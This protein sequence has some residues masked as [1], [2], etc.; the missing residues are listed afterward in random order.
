[1]RFFILYTSFFFF[2]FIEEKTIS[3][4]F[5]FSTNSCAFFVR[6]TSQNNSTFF[7]FFHTP[8]QSLIA[9]VSRVTIIYV[10]FSPRTRRST[11]LLITREHSGAFNLGNR[12]DPKAASYYIHN[13][14]F[15]SRGTTWDFFVALNHC[16]KW[17]RLLFSHVAPRHTRRTE[18]SDAS[19]T[20][21]YCS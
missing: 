4:L 2:L 6:F 19:Q 18:W 10:P 15:T 5:L 13:F 3:R 8:I 21:P 12:R 7:F 9:I 1:M 20:P 17:C 16:C 14:L 11:F